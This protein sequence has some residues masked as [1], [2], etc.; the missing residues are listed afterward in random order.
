[1]HIEVEIDDELLRRATSLTGTTDQRKLIE[2]AL[3]LLISTREHER[4]HPPHA[5]MLWDDTDDD[6]PIV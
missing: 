2:R 4:Q 1:M 5:H 3:S 6:L